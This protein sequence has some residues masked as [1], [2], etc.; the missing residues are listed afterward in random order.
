MDNSCWHFLLPL[1]RKK[2]APLP[3][4]WNGHP[5]ELSKGHW[6]SFHIY[7]YRC[8]NRV[9]PRRGRSKIVMLIYDNH[10]NGISAERPK[11]NSKKWE[12]NSIRE[13]TSAPAA[14]GRFYNR[15]AIPETPYFRKPTSTLLAQE[16]QNRTIASCRN[17]MWEPPFPPSSTRRHLTWCRK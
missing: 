9:C 12:W 10:L 8:R 15:N 3:R 6:N 2:A 7:I 16:R 11:N 4:T 13:G 1:P 14:S 17:T 5:K